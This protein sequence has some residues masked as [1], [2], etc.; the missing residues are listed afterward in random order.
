MIYGKYF[1]D[2]FYDLLTGH[3]LVTSGSVLTEIEN[4]VEIFQYSHKSK[5]WS[6]KSTFLTKIEI[7]VKK[8]K[9]VRKIEILVKNRTFRHKSK[10]WSK[11]LFGQ[12]GT[13]EH[14]LKFLTK[15]RK[16]VKNNLLP[17]I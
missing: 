17:K 8:W 2:D 4:F 13:F 6:K 9:F 14:K 12:N 1:Y 15:N 5:F 3:F 11:N 7:L 10:F 16:F